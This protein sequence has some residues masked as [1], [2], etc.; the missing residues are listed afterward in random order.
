MKSQSEI[1]YIPLAAL[2]V[3]SILLGVA[4]TTR[5]QDQFQTPFWL[6]AAI[7]FTAGTVF[8]YI[9]KVCC[10]C[11]SSRT[12]E[13]QYDEDF[14]SE[15]SWDED[16]EDL[17]ADRAYPV[18]HDLPWYERFLVKILVWFKP[19]DH[20]NHYAS[21]KDWN[22]PLESKTGPEYSRAELHGRFD[23]SNC[24]S[25]RKLDA[26]AAE[27]NL[28]YHDPTD[29]SHWRVVERRTRRMAVDVKGLQE[30]HGMD[31]SDQTD[32]PRAL[33]RDISHQL[34]KGTPKK[35]KFPWSL[36]PWSSE[37][38]SKRPNQE[39]HLSHEGWNQLPSNYEGD[40][41]REII[42]TAICSFLG[43]A[44]GTF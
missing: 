40:C 12:H 20:P 7:I 37:G 8:C 36:L 25:L 32:G 39:A 30:T 28:S 18:H 10:S 35:Q 19:A 15:D 16:E 29:H 11:Q 43:T 33:V 1:P 23:H 3:T 41:T 42:L 34:P 17:P 13:G 4:F 27:L 26:Q 9:A 2:A 6:Q 5:D 31:R 14:S 44:A 22:H 21:Q 38:T 24:K